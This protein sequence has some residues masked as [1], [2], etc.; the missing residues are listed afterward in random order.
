MY[1]TSISIYQEERKST[2]RKICSNT[3]E[4]HYI[5]FIGNFSL[6]NPQLIKLLQ[7]GTKDGDKAVRVLIWENLGLSNRG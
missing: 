3:E 6:K 5:L 7:N 1:R 4:K 2:L